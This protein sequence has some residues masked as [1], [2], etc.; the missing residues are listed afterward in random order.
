MVRPPGLS[1]PESGG[2]AMHRIARRFPQSALTGLALVA[3]TAAGCAKAPDQEI[4]AAQAA[5]AQAKAA[6]GDTYAPEPYHKA[7]EVMAQAKAEVDAQNGKFALMRSYK[8]AKLLLGQVKAEA[9]RAREEAA[10]G[11]VQFQR[12]AQIAPDEAR[13][14]LDAATAAVAN[15]PAG[16]DSRA[17]IDAMKGDLEA[18]KAT[19]AEADAANTAQDFATAKQK[20]EQVQ[21]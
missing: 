18:L 8:N 21:R 15:A 10:T 5:L 2:F 12:A 1:L 16:K 4:G 17:D 14:R 20:A 9:D 7:E 11:R 3:L 6:G 19:L 13:P